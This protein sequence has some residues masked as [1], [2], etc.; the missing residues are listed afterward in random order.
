MLLSFRK[1]VPNV[2][3]FQN[4]HGNFEHGVAYQKNQNNGVTF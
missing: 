4:W 2:P 3:Y 1:S